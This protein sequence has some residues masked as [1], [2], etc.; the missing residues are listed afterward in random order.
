MWSVRSRRRLAS[1]PETMWC[2]ERPASLGPPPMA[3][4][5]L[6][7][8]S[9][10]SRRP[11]RTSPAI[12]SASPP[13]YTSAVSMRLTPASRHMSTWR[14]ASST[15]VEPTFANP[16]VPPKV[17]VPMVSTEIRSPDLPSVRYSTEET[18][19]TGPSRPR[20]GLTPARWARGR[21]LRA[22]R[23][24]PRLAGRRDDLLG[25]DAGLAF[26]VPGRP[27]HER[28]HLVVQAD[29]R[30]GPPLHRAVERALVVRGD[31]PHDVVE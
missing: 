20:G 6:V 13:E 12:S 15:P 8:T 11:A 7:A 18:L 1:Q 25:E 30:L 3:I 4:R 2:R 16:P 17:I 14:R 9:T 23:V 19:S 21:P 27:E 26:P 22:G 24:R 28:V 10:S 29:Q 5:T 31:Q